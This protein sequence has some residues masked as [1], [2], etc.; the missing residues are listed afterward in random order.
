MQKLV[1]SNIAWE[2]DQD[3]LAYEV[4][5]QKNV[6]NVEVAPT[7]ICSNWSE[8]DSLKIQNFKQNL[9]NNEL[10][11]PSLQAIL[12]LKPELH[13][14]TSEQSRDALTQHLKF[15]IDLAEQLSETNRIS[16]STLARPTVLVFGAPKNRLKGQLSDQQ[17]DDIA[18]RFFKQISDYAAIKNCVIGLEPNARQYACDYAFNAQYAAQIVRKVNSRAFG[19]HLDTACMH[20][21]NDDFQSN[22]SNSKDV[23]THFHVSEPFLGDFAN[24]QVNHNAACHALLDARYQGYISIEKRSAKEQSIDQLIQA[25]DFVQQTYAPLL[26]Q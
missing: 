13:L 10:L 24:P 19:L 22:I 7:K 6:K 14:F 12:F 25:I 2:I 18:I 3:N 21:E 1:V 8:I 20:L 17:C 15:V 16:L 26:S 9:E 11:V 23:L 5:K 4:L